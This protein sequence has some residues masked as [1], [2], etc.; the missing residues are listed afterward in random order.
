MSEE[1]L[2]LPR[3]P[4]KKSSSEGGRWSLLLEGLASD[5]GLAWRR[6]ER[7]APRDKGRRWAREEV[8]DEEGWRTAAV[9]TRDRA[10]SMMVVVGLVCCVQYCSRCV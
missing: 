6:L 10:G 1:G 7:V 3:K 9:R 8:Q 2:R 4:P 5:A